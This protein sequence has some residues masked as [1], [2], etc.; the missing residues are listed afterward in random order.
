MLFS[1]KDYCSH[2]Q[3]SLV[4]YSLC[5]GLKLPGPAN[6]Q[7]LVHVSMTILLFQNIFQATMLAD[8]ALTL[9]IDT[10]SQ[11]SHCSSGFY[12]LSTIGMDVML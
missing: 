9:L 7:L 10:V 3:Y 1:R 11:P 12:N 5:L 8:A 2:F 6:P 4:A